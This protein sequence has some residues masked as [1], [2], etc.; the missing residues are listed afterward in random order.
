MVMPTKTTERLDTRINAALIE[1]LDAWRRKQGDMPSRAEAIRRLVEQALTS[2]DAG[3]IAI[4]N[5]NKAAE[6]AS[7]E[8]DKMGAKI[9]QGEERAHRKRALIKRDG[10]IPGNPRQTSEEQ[11]I[12]ICVRRSRSPRHHAT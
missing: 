6:L 1:R 4:E 12:M 5:Q 11:K 10:R 3:P 9:G 7:R 8:I 2:A